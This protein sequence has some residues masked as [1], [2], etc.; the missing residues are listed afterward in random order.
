MYPYQVTVSQK[1]WKGL[2][3]NRSMKREDL[4]TENKKDTGKK[5][6]FWKT[7]STETER[8]R[9]TPTLLFV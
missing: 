3:Q 4:Q 2:N 1:V 7:K 9:I 6:D 8:E 5:N